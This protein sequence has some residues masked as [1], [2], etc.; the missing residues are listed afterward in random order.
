MSVT[1]EPAKARSGLHTRASNAMGRTRDGL[2]D[3]ALASIERDGLRSTTMAGIAVRA[4]VAKAT[5]YNHFRTRDDILHAL[6]LR[7]VHAAVAASSSELVTG[8]L[9]GALAGAAMRLSSIPALRRVAETEPAALLPL[10]TP[11][12]SDGW[13]EVRALVG[14]VL[15]L[16]QPDG[17][18]AG[19]A[20]LDTEGAA[21][22]VDLVIRWAASQLLAPLEASACLTS[23]V[24]L[25]RV[26]RDSG[27]DAG[28]EVSAAR[29]DSS[30]T[31]S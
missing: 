25:A 8:D 16:G 11:G 6:V 10:L 15:A 20:S 12:E 13:V 30:D 3:G 2:L 28:L 23:A 4:G 14:S 29:A 21:A 22:V 9:A 24:L 5:L 7:E 31:S 27:A 17:G 26:L 19:E 1:A 18:A